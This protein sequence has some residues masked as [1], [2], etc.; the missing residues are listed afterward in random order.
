MLVYVSEEL[1]GRLDTYIDRVE[2]HRGGVTLKGRYIG[3]VDVS[4]SFS[5]EE[6]SALSHVIG[7]A[8]VLTCTDT[9]CMPDNDN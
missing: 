4:V 5:T 3:H 6:L 7:V 2:V 8:K 1:Q 9:G